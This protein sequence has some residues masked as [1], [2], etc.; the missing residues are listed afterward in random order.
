MA[1][2]RLVVAADV[3]GFQHSPGLWLSGALDGDKLLHDLRL[4]GL[5]FNGDWLE[6]ALKLEI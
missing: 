5:E 2:A 1:E 3:G 6:D 4:G